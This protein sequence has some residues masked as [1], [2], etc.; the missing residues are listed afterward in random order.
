M[1]VT[2]RSHGGSRE[3]WDR[4][5]TN[6]P[7]DSGALNLAKYPGKFAQ[8]VA[9]DTDG[10]MLEAG[11]GL[12]RNVIHFHN[13]GRDITGI[14]YIQTAIDKI[15]DAHPDLKVRQADVMKLPFDDQAFGGVMAFGLYHSLESGVPEALAETL[16]VLKPGGLMVASARLDNIQNRANDRIEAKKYQGGELKFHKANYTGAEFRTLLAEAGFETEKMEYV[17]NMP[18]FY[19]FRFFRSPKHKDFDEGLGRGEGYQLSWLGN[20]LQRTLV[21]LFPRSFCNIVV[22]FARRPAA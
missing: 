10:P 21:T 7:V 9:D 2:Y 22:A 11:C 18:L 6:A 20:A 12:G 1:R 14:D 15:K 3:Y 13:L 8:A 5:W 16:R 19:K 4:R 17:E